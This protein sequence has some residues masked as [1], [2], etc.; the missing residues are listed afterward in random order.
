METLTPYAPTDKSSLLAFLKRN[1]EGGDGDED[2]AVA[3]GNAAV[4]WMEQ[5]TF[6][7][8]M[9]RTYRNPVTLAGL[10]TAGVNMTGAGFLA[11]VKQDDDILSTGV[12]AGARVSSITNDGA[13]VMNQ[14]GVDSAGIAATF[15]SAPLRIDGRDENHFY[16]PERPLIALFSVVWIDANG[17]RTSVDL[18]NARFDPATGRVRILGAALPRGDMNVEIECYAGYRAPSGTVLGDWA[19]HRALRRICHRAAQ[20]FFQDWATSAGR[21]VSKTLGPGTSVLPNFKMPDDIEA[22]IAPYERHW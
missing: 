13:L 10:T 9:A 3:A 21:M 1:F 4:A 5:R 18:T 12:N 6:R 20:V 16:V 19:D 22:M 17:L 8:L 14:L 15:G 11:G 2:Q 7:R